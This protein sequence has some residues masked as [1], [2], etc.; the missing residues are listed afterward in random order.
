MLSDA[1]AHARAEGQERILGVVDHVGRIAAAVEEPLRAELVRVRPPHLR[2]PRG[3]P[4]AHRQ[5]PVLRDLD[6]A[7][8]HRSEGVALDEV[9]ERRVQPQRLLDDRGEVRELVVEHFPEPRVVGGVHAGRGRL[10]LLRDSPLGLGVGRQEVRQVRERDRGGVHPAD[11]ERVQHVDRLVLRQAALLVLRLAQRLE[12]RAL[13]AGF[14]RAAALPV[15]EPHQ[16]PAG[17][18]VGLADP[19]AQLHGAGERGVEVGVEEVLDLAHPVED[20]GEDVEDLRLLVLG[21]DAVAERDLHDG[22]EGEAAEQG[23]HLVLA[24]DGDGPAALVPPVALGLQAGDEGGRA[25]PY[26][27]QVAPRVPRADPAH[28]DAVLPPPRAGPGGEDALAQEQ[29]EHRE[30]VVDEAV[31]LLERDLRRERLAGPLRVDEEERGLV[32]HPARREAAGPGRLGLDRLEEGQR[33][34]AHAGHVPER[35][36]GPLRALQDAPV[37][38][39]PVEPALEDPVPEPYGRAHGGEGAREEREREGAHRAEAGEA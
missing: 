30:G 15:A 9:G 10:H 4:R 3:D 5:G 33:V 8:L 28:R 14:G 23:A 21:E 17:E 6:G 27:G 20:L 32:H 38:A 34:L 24:G 7:D 26:R 12:H 35:E 36:R 39:D 19:P 11:H 13:R 22:P 2:E 18:L 31:A 16:D 1:V 29:A 37:E 25:A